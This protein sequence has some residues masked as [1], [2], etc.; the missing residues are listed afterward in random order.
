[1]PQYSPDPDITTDMG[2]KTSNIKQPAIRMKPPLVRFRMGD[3]YGGNGGDINMML[4]FIKSISYGICAIFNYFK[5]V[6]FCNS[7]NF[8]PF[9]NIS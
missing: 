8:F 3:L 9:T 4:G 6:F 7:I 1:M 5:I 2:Y